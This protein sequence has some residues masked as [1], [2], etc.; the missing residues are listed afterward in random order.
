MTSVSTRSFYVE[1]V[2]NVTV[3]CF[4]VSKVIERNYELIS[5]ELFE[6]VEY[7]TSNPPAQVVLDL[8]S[9]RQIDDWGLAMLRAFHETVETHDG[10]TVLCRLSP[11]VTSALRDASLMSGFNTR[12]TRGEAITSFTN[13]SN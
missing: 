12:E 1:Q 7:V 8:F 13:R 9:I 10:T 4:T 6:L 3:L 11:A 2:Q 5:D